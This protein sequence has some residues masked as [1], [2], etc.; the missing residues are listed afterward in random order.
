ML[1]ENTSAAYQYLQDENIQAFNE[2]MEKGE[3]VDLRHSIFR[4]LDL[5]GAKFKGLDLSGG[6]FKSSDL[7]GLDLRGCNMDGCSIY[8]AKIS[9]VFFPDGLSPEEINLS[10]IHGTRMRMKS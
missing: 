9:G 7:R 3:M 10:L 4:G 5:K 1:K 2:M 6:H 8:N